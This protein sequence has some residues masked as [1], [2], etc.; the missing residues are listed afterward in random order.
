MLA[1]GNS[2]NQQRWKLWRAL[3]FYRLF[4]ENFSLI[5]LAFVKAPTRLLLH[6]SIKSRFR[7]TLFYELAIAF[8]TVFRCL[9]RLRVRKPNHEPNFALASWLLPLEGYDTF[10]GLLLYCA[11]QSYEFIA[12]ETF[13]ELRNW[14]AR[15]SQEPL[16][17]GAISQ[18]F[19][20]LRL[21][22]LSGKIN[23]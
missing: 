12:L 3:V 19:K 15:R 14:A 17:L 2:L 7:F 10:C 9:W 18:C 13:D 21:P 5:F 6:H 1:L 16:Q 20:L 11:W 22:T 23:F 4:N 8:V